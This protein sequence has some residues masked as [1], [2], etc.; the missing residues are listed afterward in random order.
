MTCKDCL[1]SKV[2]KDWWSEQEENLFSEN[3]IA[4]RTFTDRSEWMHL[5]FKVGDTV[6]FITGIHNTLI[7]DA[8]VEEL[9]IDETGVS[10][11]GVRTDNNIYFETN[12]NEFYSTREKA[13]EE[14][15]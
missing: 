4:C 3:N 12:T 9:S 5:P 15:K 11:I 7:K 13:L 6:W 8:K 10:Y 1:H 2:C 14:M